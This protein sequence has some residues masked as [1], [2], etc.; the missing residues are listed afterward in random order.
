MG[1]SAPLFLFRAKG[2]GKLKADKH[3]GHQ[4]RWVAHRIVNGVL[5]PGFPLG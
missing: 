2:G 3:T 1:A 5:P 4:N